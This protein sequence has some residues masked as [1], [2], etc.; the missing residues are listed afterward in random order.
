MKLV[1]AVLGVCC[2]SLIGTAGC[3]GEQDAEGA[4]L[5]QLQPVPGCDGGADHVDGGH[6]DHD[7]PDGGTFPVGIDA[8][9]GVLDG[10]G[11]PDPACASLTYASFGEPFLEKYCIGC[12]LGARAVGGVDLSTLAGLK[13]NA[14]QVVAHAV[15][16]PVVKPMPP[17]GARQP[18]DAERMQLGQWI[19]C[20]PK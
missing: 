13:M 18:T 1:I 17:A 20:G 10:G 8:G 7:H 16:K 3:G 2:A 6:H 15:E 14:E 19:S 9:G 12:H 11:A 4:D 5:A